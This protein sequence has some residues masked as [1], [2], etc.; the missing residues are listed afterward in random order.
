MYSNKLALAH[1]M[2][3]AKP[4]SDRQ[5]IVCCC[6]RQGW[7]GEDSEKSVRHQATLHYIWC[8]SPYGKYTVGIAETCLLVI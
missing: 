7:A 6:E 1:Y 4:S 8:I 3:R 2:N 5:K